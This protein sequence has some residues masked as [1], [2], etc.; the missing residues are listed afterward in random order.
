MSSSPSNP[1][2]TSNKSHP[3]PASRVS[4]AIRLTCLTALCTTAVSPDA[5][6]L[7]LRSPDSDECRCNVV[8]VGIVQKHTRDRNSTEV[9]KLVTLAVEQTIHGDPRRSV[10]FGTDESVE[11][12]PTEVG[13]RLLLFLWE[14]AAMD[15]PV[16][17]DPY[18]GPIMSEWRQLDSTLPLSDP[19]HAQSAWSSRC[20][21]VVVHPEPDQ[22]YELVQTV[23][24]AL[25]P[26]VLWSP[27]L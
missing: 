24:N 22:V 14:D 6:A 11:S 3:S 17:A 2:F 1:T 12:P 15:Q 10:T 27:S 4:F 13:T 18:N 8:V 16:V 23:Q 9:T 7:R 21:P 5:H 19:H 26:P 25:Q 20:A